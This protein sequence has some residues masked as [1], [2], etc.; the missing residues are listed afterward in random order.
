MWTSVAFFERLCRGWIGGAEIGGHQG[1]HR[2]KGAQRSGDLG[3]CRVSS[4]GRFPAV[5]AAVG[6]R[7]E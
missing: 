5:V 2:E 3:C 4:P 7:L 1:D 6:R